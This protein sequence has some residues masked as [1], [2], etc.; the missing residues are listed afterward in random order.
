MKLGVRHIL[1]F[2]WRVFPLIRRQQSRHRLLTW[3]VDG[4]APETR[5]LEAARLPTAVVNV[6]DCVLHCCVSVFRRL[7]AVA[8]TA[9]SRGETHDKNN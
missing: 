7:C 2:L 8:D 1:Y 9:S 3:D 4:L 5:C 6:R